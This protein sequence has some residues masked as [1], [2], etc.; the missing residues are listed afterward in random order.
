MNDGNFSIESHASL[1]SVW[2]FLEQSVREKISKRLLNF[3]S[4]VKAVCGCVAFFCS[5]CVTN[6]TNIKKYYYKGLRLFNTV[7]CKS[8]V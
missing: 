1:L 5:V 3:I 2:I 6:I 8:Q 4:E 7:Q